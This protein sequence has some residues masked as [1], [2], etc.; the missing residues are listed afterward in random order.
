MNFGARVSGW[1]WPR[2]AGLMVR[3][4]H[5]FLA[6]RHAILQ[7]VDDLIALLDG[8]SGPLWAALLVIVCAALNIPI[9]WRKASLGSQLTWIG[10][11]IDIKH[12]V[13]TLPQEKRI[14]ILALICKVLESSK[15]PTKQLE[16]LIGKLLWLTLLWRQLWP[17][18]SPLYALLHTCPTS[19][20]GFSQSDWAT[21]LSKCD[22]MLCLQTPL[23]HPKLPPGARFLRLG[24]T[25]LS[26][27]AHA[28]SV[29]LPNKRLWIA[30]Q[31]PSNQERVLSPTATECLSTWKMLLDGLVMQFSMF[32]SQ[33]VECHALA[34]AMADQYHAGFGGVAYF[35]GGV[36][37]WFRFR[38]TLDDIPHSFTWCKGSMQSFISV[39]ELFAQFCLSWM[40]WDTCG[41]TFG[42]LI[43][44]QLCDNTSAEAVSH[45]GLA[46]TP[47]LSHMLGIYFTWLRRQN[48]V[49]DIS[50]IPGEQNTVADGLSRFA[51]LDDLHLE[52]SV[53]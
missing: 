13:I 32:P 50:H 38:W 37:K 31:D 28:A 33:L 21:A 22:E 34:D 3:T 4:F 26:D 40:I 24:N 20:L 27:K 49:V 52:A 53:G 12:W 41:R 47:G 15:V 9:S 35:P 2:L 6:F 8:A 42:R 48:I 19:L 11:R 29:K 14:S 51:P 36:T 39:W 18:L 45:K 10:W 44:R 30:V 46:S 25:T 43:F 16:Q 17:L 23:Y 5:Q 1:Y 7:Y